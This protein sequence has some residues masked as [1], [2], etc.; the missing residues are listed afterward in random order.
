MPENRLFENQ[1]IGVYGSTGN[2]CAEDFD[3]KDLSETEVTDGIILKERPALSNE[4]L[5]QFGNIRIEE[6]EKWIK[7]ISLALDKS[8]EEAPTETLANNA[9]RKKSVSLKNYSLQQIHQQILRANTVSGAAALL[10]T[11]PNTYSGIWEN[12]FLRGKPLSYERLREL[13]PEAVEAILGA[14]YHQP[15]QADKVD[16]RDYTLAHIHQQILNANNVTLAATSLGTS[17]QNL[18][19]RLSI[20]IY[21]GE[22][23]S[24]NALR[25]LTQEA[26]AAL[27]GDAYHQ[28]MQADRTDLRKYTLAYIHQQILKASSVNEAAAL[29]GTSGTTLEIQ[30]GRVIYQEQPLSFDSLK[31]LTLEAALAV[32]GDA[33]HQPM[34]ADKVNLR[35]YT[36]AHIHQQIIK[37]KTAKG[38]AA[39]LGTNATTLSMHLGK[40][41][42]LGQPLSIAY[43]KQLS[44]E[45]AE[46]MWGEA[47][48]QPLQTDKTNL[49]T[50]TLFHIHQQILNSRNN[51]G[52][53][54]SL[55]A[56]SEALFRYLSKF[57]YDGQPLTYDILKQLLP[58]DAE[59]M[60]GVSYHQRM[61]ASKKS[62][63]Q[64]FT[65]SYIHEQ[66]LK[67]DN[68]TRAASL[69]GVNSKTLDTHL[70]KFTCE[71]ESLSYN[72]LK[73]LSQEAA[74]ALW[75]NAYHQPMQAKR[76]ELKNY[77]LAHIHQK[78]ISAKNQTQAAALLGTGRKTL[79]GHLAKLIYQRQPLSFE[80]LKH[81]SQDDA[82]KIW[83]DFY[84][85]QIMDLYMPSTAPGLISDTD[86]AVVSQRKRNEILE[87]GNTLENGLEEPMAQEKQRMIVFNEISNLN[88]TSLNEGFTDTLTNPFGFFANKKIKTSHIT[89]K[90][91]N[92][93]NYGNTEMS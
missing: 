15:M 70:G 40:L 38:A 16:L 64:T 37:T 13:S 57:N 32:W 14:A 43:L 77:T 21:D 25:T 10:G 39:L 49:G 69:L 89:S 79:A 68:I 65:L 4:E 41:T 26:A 83:G 18:Y 3:L 45:D 7:D 81:L 23:L 29:L 22:P 30:L 92:G 6:H 42:C 11:S 56:S 5:L 54:A 73:L 84:F 46:A 78:V 55:G 24:Y 8:E 36:L 88:S 1:K 74:A 82:Q 86:E 72:A 71:G 62:T 53:A 17:P 19:R 67:A 52:A 61:E 80:V 63:L 20:F 31:Q 91:N 75:G 33:Y 93:F 58:E 50:F 47:Y 34:Q 44:Q 85:K 27:W 76:T 90:P 35:D 2:P 28:P 60:W 48:H 12:L 9:V 66:I 51:S 59:A 87:D